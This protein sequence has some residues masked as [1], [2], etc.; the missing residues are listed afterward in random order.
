MKENM[1]KK[2][3][4]V[5]IVIS[6]LFMMMACAG[7]NEESI[8]TPDDKIEDN[9]TDVI[10]DDDL[11]MIYSENPERVEVTK[12][13][14]IEADYDPTSIIIKLKKSAISNEQKPDISKDLANLGVVELTHLLGR[15]SNA[16]KETGIWYNARLEED[17]DAKDIIH[18]VNGL[19]SVEL[20]ELNYVYKN[21]AIDFHKVI[22]NPRV[23][24]QWHLEN[25]GVQEAWYW[26]EENGYEAG[27][28]SSVVIAIIDTG[29]D[30]TH[31]DLA[32]N[33]WVNPN[34]IPGN[35]IDDDGNGFIDDVHGVNVV[36][37]SRFHSGDPMDDHGHGTHVAGIAAA[38]NN[39]EGIVGV[40]YNSKI[41]AIKAGNANGYFLQTDI[42]EAILYA[43]DHGADVI[44]M[45]FGGTTVSNFVQDAL[46]IAY[47]R[48]VL[49]ASAG[50]DNKPNEGPQR[51]EP[52][53]NYP[54]AY[55]YVIGVMSTNKSNIKSLFSNW[56]LYESSNIEYEIYAP[57]EQMISTLP[58]NQYASWSG[59][60]MSAPVVSGIAALLRPLYLDRDI[61]P[62]KY[63][64]GQIVATADRFGSEANMHIVNAYSAFTKIP[65][66]LITV[67]DS[68]IL[69][70]NAQS[71]NNNSDRV[72]DAG[73]I[74]HLGLILQNK[75]GVAS[76]T[77]VEVTTNDDRFVQML[78]STVS[79][80]SIGTY[81]F[82]DNDIQRNEGF[83][84]TINSP[85]ILSISNEIP[86]DY[87]IQLNIKITCTNGLD[88]NDGTI[89]SFESTL[90][91]TVVN[92]VKL[93]G[94]INSDQIWSNDRYYIISDAV[95]IAEGVTVIVEP[96]TKIQ[97]WSADPENPYVD[98]PNP[99]LSV[100]GKL[101][102]QGTKENPIDIFPSDL[103]F[104]H[105]IRISGNK[106][107]EMEYVNIINIATLIGVKKID[108][109][110]F[111]QSSDHVMGRY[112]D[113]QGKWMPS[114]ETP[115]IA[116]DVVV[117]STF[118][119]VGG[120]YHPLTIDSPIIMN[121]AF[122]KSHMVLIVD[123][124]KII[125]DNVFIDNVKNGNYNSKFQGNA[126]KMEPFIKKIVESSESTYV[127]IDAFFWQKDA[128]SDFAK[129]LGGSLLTINSYEEYDR[130]SE[131]FTD[132]DYVIG[133]DK[134][135]DGLVYWQSK[136][137]T[138]NTTE[139]FDF[140]N[141]D[142]VVGLEIYEYYVLSQGTIKA[143]KGKPTM[144]YIIELPNSYMDEPI[145][146][147]QEIISIKVQEAINLGY[148]LGPASTFAYNSILNNILDL[149]VTKWFRPDAYLG[150]AGSVAYNY[151]GTEN[152]DMVRLQTRQFPI[153]DNIFYTPF[154]I[155]PNENNYPHVSEIKILNSLQEEVK[156][157]GNDEIIIIV[158]FN[159]DMDVSLPL[160]VT[161]GSSVPYAEYVIEGEFVS[162]RRW[163][164]TY[165][166]KTLIENGYQYISVINGASVND[167][168]LRLRPDV[169]RFMF[170]ID[171][172]S[173]Q[174]LIMQGSAN[175]EG[176]NLSW[177]QD[178]FDTLAGY[179]VYRSTSEDGFYQRLNSS[180]IPV[181][182]E[183]FFDDSVEPG[184]TYYYNFT[185]VKTDLTE[186]T[187]SGKIVIQSLDTMA[188]NIYHSPV[189][190]TFINQNILIKANIIDNLLIQSARLYYRNVGDSEWKAS[191]M[192]PNN[193][194]YSTVIPSNALSLSGLEY[195]IEAYDGI[196]YT[197][198]GSSTNPYQVIVKNAI[199]EKAYGDVN[200]DGVITTIDALMLLQAIND[201]INLT[202]EQFL[203]ADLNENGIL[204]A[205][206]ALRILQ[207]TS[208]KVTTIR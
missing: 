172:T 205:W 144:S 110:N 128:I 199:D 2:V 95:N 62:N 49:V 207:Y 175:E 29:V 31:K 76:D 10:P 43:Y 26:L 23:Q 51:V 69:D 145:T 86:N 186:S 84:T 5:L 173:A 33:M 12:L 13:Y 70:D 208:G 104:D 87:I 71:I 189:Y 52:K 68:F 25:A 206:E 126:D 42:A 188:P 133:I 149:D 185:V 181:G 124:S 193:D 114:R 98:L 61:Y 3:A 187:P 89:Y 40:A 143:A 195:Y 96:G 202:A 176:I 138:N 162:S 55:S 27:G 14:D 90:E 166:L 150:F 72:I 30:Y 60:S 100:S 153:T 170:E 201:R 22:E 116:A 37:D 137:Y 155:D 80:D 7:L 121:N 78:Q 15:L 8:L 101:I 58:D 141:H 127:S 119:N 161:F 111:S 75:W 107:I 191:T 41:M 91:F 17:I 39:K 196:S 77:T 108:H 46:S 179:N 157:V 64:R 18:E 88:S 120:I 79:Y 118:Y 21:E 158:E 48:S 125:T 140:I 183:T 167:G 160:L 146:W 198:K 53:P 148:H 122:Q 197:Y 115:I 134:I 16:D 112:V 50:N 65:K 73:E 93:S 36:S 132:T 47:T 97:F 106:N 102:M 163:E 180:I 113:Y 178:D 130:L 34:E 171:T 44:N 147:T 35:G 204:E 156:K 142:D 99:G 24:E 159:R 152:E 131:I 11:D 56:D 184:V 38:A 169:K 105:G 139:I 164:G 28:S 94:V 66:P 182:S 92:G 82:K 109:V 203:R 194:Q 165:T 81:N 9:S 67:Y 117:N 168:W 4:M 177:I 32:A 20:V 45:S 190:Q 1:F 57:G 123:N 63:I 154:L 129:Y 200:G 6:S 151:W 19:A 83:I 136:D 174:A 74:V 192:T 54:A 135:Q 103:K 59:T 85:F